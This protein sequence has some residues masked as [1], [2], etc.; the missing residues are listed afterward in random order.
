MM[1][2]ETLPKSSCRKNLLG[3]DRSV[4]YDA[5]FSAYKH[6]EL[7]TPP[8]FLVVSTQDEFT[9]SWD[10]MPY[11]RAMVENN[12]PVTL[13]VYPTDNYGWGVGKSEAF[14]NGDLFKHDLTV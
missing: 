9:G 1:Q 13:H 10:S 5:R 7:T 11:T 4:Q 6:V 2:E 8:A 14:P 3:S 12:R